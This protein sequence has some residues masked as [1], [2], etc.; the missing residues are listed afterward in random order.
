M[1]GRSFSMT[2]SAARSARPPSI[3]RSR[4]P[5]WVAGPR[6]RAAFERVAA[7]YS[8]SAPQS[9]P[10]QLASDIAR[11]K[12]WCVIEFLAGYAQGTIA[13]AFPIELLLNEFPEWVRDVGSW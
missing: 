3:S 7:V 8:G 6:S 10:R 4:Y 1:M 5:G 12:V 13:P 11:A 2:G 9:D